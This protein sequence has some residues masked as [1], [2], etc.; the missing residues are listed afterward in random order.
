MP[1]LTNV[2]YLYQRQRLRVS[3]QRRAAEPFFSLSA[4]EQLRL[5]TYFGPT[6]DFTDK[7]AIA[8]R[9]AISERFSA[10]PQQAGRAYVRVLPYLVPEPRSGPVMRE[11]RFKKPKGEVVVFGVRRKE[12]DIAMLTRALVNLIKE[13]LKNDKKN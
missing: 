10:L 5:W 13:D 11:R 7:E 1:R 4:T 3:W 6:Q 8:H 2:Q 12:V 9:K